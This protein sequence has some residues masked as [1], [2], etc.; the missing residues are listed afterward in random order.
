IAA[1]HIVG[2]EQWLGYA[3]TS[4]YVLRPSIAAI[5]WTFLLLSAGGLTLSL[6]KTRS[7]SVIAFLAAIAVQAIALFVLAKSRGAD[8]PYLALKMMYLAIYP[9]AVCGALAIARLIQLAR[10]LWRPLVG[11]LLVAFISVVIAT[12]PPKLAPVITKPALEA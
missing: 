6:T 12:R 11:G 9:L 2:R 5:G 7:R 1:V 4:G 3:A 8:P 10:P